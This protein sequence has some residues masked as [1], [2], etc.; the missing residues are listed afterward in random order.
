LCAMAARG[1]TKQV[2]ADKSLC[3]FRLP[4]SRYWPKLRGLWLSDFF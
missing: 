3:E 2:P 1:M 4:S